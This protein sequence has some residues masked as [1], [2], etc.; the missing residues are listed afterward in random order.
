MDRKFMDLAIIRARRAA[1]EGEVPV[2]AIIVKDGQVIAT[3]R[4]RREKNHDAT[5]HAE[6]E[7]IKYACEVTGDWRLDGCELYVT[8]EPCP[9]CS[10]AIIN[11]R[12]KTVIF[13][14]YDTKCGAL[15]SVANFANLPF[16]YTPEVYGGICEDECRT[17]LTDFFK[18]KRK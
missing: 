15:G 12:I 18:D 2:G 7:A 14:A 1:E 6:I 16:N 3:G 11:S 13:G 4:N 17:L 10:G 9:M 8:L 5:A